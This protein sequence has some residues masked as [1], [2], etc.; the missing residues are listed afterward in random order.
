MA[1]LIL[2]RGLPGSGKNL[3]ASMLD[4]NRFFQAVYSADDY[5]MRD[6]VYEFDPTK[7]PQAHAECQGAVKACVSDGVSVAVANTF[8]CRW[9][10]EPYI[11]MVLRKDARLIVVDM[12]DAGLS[13][14]QLA[15]RNTHGVPYETIKAMRGRYEH[16]WKNG[17]PLPPWDRN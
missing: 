4:V 15:I 13:D 2:I 1:D 10:M 7:L 14:E 17:N 11:Q 16:D 3:L 9:E 8:T 5:F 12:F 6:G